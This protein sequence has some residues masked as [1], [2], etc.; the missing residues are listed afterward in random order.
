MQSLQFIESNK[1]A[2]KGQMVYFDQS[3][4][5]IKLTSISSSGSY[6]L[7]AGEPLKE[8]I[9]RHGP[10]VTNTDEEMKK[11]NDNLVIV[12]I[13]KHINSQVGKKFALTL[14]IK[15]AK[16][17]Y[18]LLTDADCKPNSK[19]WVKKMASNFHHSEILLGY[20]SYK[21]TKGLL[22]KM[23]RFDTFNVAQ[24]YLSFAIVGLTS[25]AF[26]NGYLQLIIFSKK[27]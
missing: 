3:S 19:N 9:I 20:G 18:L 6:L 21:K 4:T 2:S 16:N 7:L 5:E 26:I 17:E 10:F 12:T 23:I 11:D 22:N 24:Q 8:S 25:H 13:D 1:I 27:C 14:G 15:T